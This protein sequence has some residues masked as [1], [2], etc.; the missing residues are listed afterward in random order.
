MVNC[1]VR[2]VR[3]IRSFD[4]LSHTERNKKVIQWIIEVKVKESLDTRNPIVKSTDLVRNLAT[5]EKGV[6][7]GKRSSFVVKQKEGEFLSSLLTRA[8][9]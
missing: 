3:K 2:A 1:R 5:G 7:Y 9:P 6:A 8:L 4:K